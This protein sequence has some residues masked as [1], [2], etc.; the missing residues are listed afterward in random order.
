MAKKAAKAKK[1][2]KAAALDKARYGIGEWYGRLMPSL[3]PAER[4]VYGAIGMTKSNVPCPFRQAAAPGS[5]CNKLGGVCSLRLHRTDDSTVTLEGQLVTVCPSR[6][7]HG[8][9]IFEWIGKEMVGTDKPKL[10]KEVGFLEALPGAPA[11]GAAIGPPAEEETEETGPPVGRIDSVLMNP[12]DPSKWC[13]L[14]MQAVYFSGKKMGTHLTQYGDAPAVP[15]FPDR[16]RRPD[17]RSS[18][19]KRLMPQLMTKIPSL[20]RWGK[21]MAVVIDAG[22]RRSL[23]PMTPV[24]HLS[25]ADIAWFIVDYDLTTGDILLEKTVYTTLESSVEALTAGIPSSQEAFEKRLSDALAAGK[26]ISL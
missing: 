7:W 19:P 24:K 23:G 17:W 21:K 9:K 12:S 11:A 20:R 8:N 25:N 22:F 13:A 16:N 2:K 18:G 14:E 1:V 6:F 26:A 4:K 10:I 15:V 5:I 3:T